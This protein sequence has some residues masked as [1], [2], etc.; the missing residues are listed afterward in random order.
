MGKMNKFVETYNLPRLTENL[1]RLFMS[2]KSE[3]VIKKKK[4]SPKGKT[5][6]QIISLVNSTKHLKK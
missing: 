5:Q 3:S 4:N 2:K 1:T 6:E